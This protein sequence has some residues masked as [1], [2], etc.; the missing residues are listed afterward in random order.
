[1]T[2]PHNFAPF[3]VINMSCECLANQSTAGTSNVGPAAAVDEIAEYFCP[4]RNCSYSHQFEDATK[5]R[6]TLW[7]EKY[8][9]VFA[10]SIYLYNGLL[11]F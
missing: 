2:R 9:R 1:M 11:V 6:E 4:K 7:S 3:G 5:C 10:L 8:A